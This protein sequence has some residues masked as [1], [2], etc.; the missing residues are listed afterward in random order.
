LDVC[1]QCECTGSTSCHFKRAEGCRRS[2]NTQR[3]RLQVNKWVALWNW[4]IFVISRLVNCR[5]LRTVFWRD[6]FWV[7]FSNKNASAQM[8][9]KVFIFDWKSEFLSW[10][11]G[12]LSRPIPWPGNDLCYFRFQHV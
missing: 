10:T 2:H 5:P 7:T 6:R 11:L 3:G 4:P 9:Q 1:G 12:S 8:I